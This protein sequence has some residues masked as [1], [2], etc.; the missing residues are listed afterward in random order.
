VS[1]PAPAVSVIVGTIEHWPVVRP[2]LDRLLPQV[3]RAGGELILADGT[4]DG[5]GAA[6][7]AHEGYGGVT[8][9][10]L[11]GA[12]IFALRAKAA[13]L[14]RAPILAFTE[15]HCL[16]SPTWVADLLR[17]HAAHPDADMVA[18]PVT[19]GSSDGF[20][21][22]AN[23]LMTF[24]EF[25]PPPPPRALRRTPPMG[26]ASFHRRVL[27]GGE[28]PEGWL[29]VVLA[30]TLVHERRLRYDAGIQVSHVQP[31]TLG[32][33]MAAHFNNGRACAG[34]ARP[35]MARRDWWKRLA[36]VPVQP[37]VLFTSVLRSIG[38]RQIPARARAS[39]PMMSLLCLAHS[40]GELA[41]LL[42]GEG[43][44]AKKLN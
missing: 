2:C 33:A 29:E 42:F 4:P 7:H 21:D 12:S 20:A 9:V 35:H 30:P 28:L 44:S 3:E 31:R 23:F 43:R 15:D 40:S 16:V 36:A 32:A 22:W 37:G 13:R 34:L 5:S 19:N 18:G 27:L 11:P 26:N 14:A 6:P 41:G 1:A 10:R 25:M 17:A 39:L 38:G 8:S 24:A